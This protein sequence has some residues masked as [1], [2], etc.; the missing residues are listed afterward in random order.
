MQPF[1]SIR[2]YSYDD[3]NCLFQSYFSTDTIN[4]ISQKV[5]EGTSKLRD[6]GRPVMVRDEEILS[7]MNQIWDAYSPDKF[8]TS[9]VEE[10]IRQVINT[11]VSDISNTYRREKFLSSVDPKVAALSTRIHPRM[12]KLRQRGPSRG[13]WNTLN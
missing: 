11:I 12:V 10:L 8:A 4:Y 9:A 5:L 2:Y 3:S 13:I 6:D 1:Y 7:V